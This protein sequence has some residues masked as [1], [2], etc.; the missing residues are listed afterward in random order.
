[1]SDDP[2]PR[3]LLPGAEP[4]TRAGR[5]WPVA[6]EPLPTSTGELLT[7]LPGPGP[8]CDPQLLDLGRAHLAALRAAR[9][10]LHDGAVLALAGR[11]PDRRLLT[12]R[13]GYFDMLATCDALREEAERGGE[14]VRRRR[15]LAVCPDPLTSGTGRCAALGVS[16]LLTVPD[17]VDGVPRAVL[18]RRSAAVATDPGRWHV[19]P[20]GMLEDGTLADGRPDPAA[21]TAA[22]E[23]AEELGLEL[24]SAQLASRARVLGLAH[25]LLRLRPDVV[26]RLDLRAAEVPDAAAPDLGLR[27]GVEFDRL[28]TVRL[29]AA[30]LRRLWQGPASARLTPAAAGALALAAELG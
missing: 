5:S 6:L 22:T 10:G 14:P 9:P 19:A 3:S 17:P 27:P 25:D 18:G 13:G 11:G 8:G 4:L 7:P 24:P 20:S 15:A 16:V 29:D 1:M 30:G 23:L 28:A 2:A 21:C 26:L 12:T